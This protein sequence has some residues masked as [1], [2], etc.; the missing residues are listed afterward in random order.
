MG[1]W[2]RL[3]HHHQE[4]NQRYIFILDGNIGIRRRRRT[5]EK[6]TSNEIVFIVNIDVIIHYVFHVLF[7]CH[8]F[9]VCCSTN[10]CD[11]S[12][13][14]FLPTYPILG[15]SLFMFF[16]KIYFHFLF[17]IYRVPHVRIILVGIFFC[18]RSSD[19]NQLT[20]H[21]KNILSRFN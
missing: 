6:K 13:D 8:S 11:V 16:R 3:R 20:P 9:S 5:R 18:L 4:T 12:I 19:H 15:F 1:R 21:K 2:T 7:R 17:V 10:R 14:V